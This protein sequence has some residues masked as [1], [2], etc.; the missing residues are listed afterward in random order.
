MGVESFFVKLKI[1][2][3]NEDNKKL[4]YDELKKKYKV[5]KE[6]NYLVLDKRIEMEVYDETEI[7]LIGCFSDFIKNIIL[8][9]NIIGFLV[10][11]IKDEIWITIMGKEYNYTEINFPKMV[12]DN[13]REKYKGFIETFGD[14]KKAINPRNFYKKKF[15]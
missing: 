11:S 1:N 4:I 14:K 7:V 13:Y 2:K 12:E 6:K 10:D 9:D 8:M 3:S 5:K 15:F